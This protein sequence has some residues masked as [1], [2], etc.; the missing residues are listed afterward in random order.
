MKTYTCR[1]YV[2]DS[3]MAFYHAGDVDKGVRLEAAAAVGA[4]S[5][6]MAAAAEARALQATALL[7]QACSASG[8]EDSTCTNA[9]SNVGPAQCQP[10]HA[11]GSEVP[12]TLDS[13]S[14]LTELLLFNEPEEQVQ[15]QCQAL[16]PGQYLLCLCLMACH[17]VLC[18]C[19]GAGADIPVAMAAPCERSACGGLQGPR[20]KGEGDRLSCHSLTAEDLAGQSP[21]CYYLS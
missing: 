16:P 17:H 18:C 6:G 4:M 5:Q 11:A 19:P 7:Q 8:C 13:I 15:V 9:W 21:L 12:L 10:Q 20:A 14:S 3:Q 1:T 2:H